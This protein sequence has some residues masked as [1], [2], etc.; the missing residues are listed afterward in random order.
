MSPQPI[1]PEETPKKV[2]ARWF[3]R[4]RSGAMSA[5]EL[6]ELEVW[7]SQDEAHRRAFDHLAMIW[8][9]AE[10][11][12]NDPEVMQMREAA[13]RSQV[14][15]RWQAFAAMAAVFIAVCFV[16]AGVANWLTAGSN[17]SPELVAAA[18]HQEF[19][20]SV[21]QTATVTLADGSVVTLDTD[22]VLRTRT[23]WNRRYAELAKGRAFF[24]VAHEKTRPFVV[25]A[26]GR[27][28]TA[29][30]TSFE[31]AVERGRFEVTLV[32]GKVRVEQPKPDDRK[33]ATLK[34]G[35]KL[36][37]PVEGAWQ[38]AT[39][40]IARETSWVEG[41]LRFR[42]E[43]L[44]RVAAELNKYSKKKVVIDDPAISARP[45][46]G[47][48]AAG[49][50]DEFVRAAEAYGLARVASNSSEEVVLIAPLD[51]APGVN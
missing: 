49:D 30:G 34:P 12:R 21:G 38:V 15:R 28:V 40:D 27:T 29:L 44:G 18:D 5:Q 6:R 19:R 7:L 16:G 46:Q 25:L 37:A 3:A 10:G 48:F 1:M 45:I 14:V 36:V 2:A 42:D 23:T 33:A 39:A 31:V 17:A 22:T 47:A 35:T 11:T 41:L 51:G 13:R 4:R 20:T 24:R 8:G 32:S 50:V 9:G 26:N 43:P